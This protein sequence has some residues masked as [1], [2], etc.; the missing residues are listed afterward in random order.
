MPILGRQGPKDQEK[1]RKNQIAEACRWPAGNFR[2][3][4][5]FKYTQCNGLF[6][7]AFNDRGE[8]LFYIFAVF[9]KPLISMSL[10]TYLPDQV[11]TC[12]ILSASGCIRQSVTAI[13]RT[14]GWEIGSVL[15]VSV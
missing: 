10:T 12:A 5:A 9:C 11:R 7:A 8:F 3:T 13:W 15:K 6:S 2:P 4:T 14:R 1:K